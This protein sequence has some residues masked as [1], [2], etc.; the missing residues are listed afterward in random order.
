MHPK[1]Q[2]IQ[3]RRTIQAA[4]KN[5]IGPSG[6]LGII[7]RHLG[8]MIIDQDGGGLYDSRYI[9]THSIESAPNEDIPVAEDSG[10]EFKGSI[11]G[12]VFDGLSRGMHL[13]IKYL[14]E[15][16]ELSVYYKGYE[17]YREVAGDLFAYAPFPEWENL[18]EKL[19]SQAKLKQREYEDQMT[20]IQ[21]AEDQED[22]LSFL[23]HLRRRWGI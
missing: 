2:E 6:K 3:Q 10:R 14:K 22:R 15:S 4:S 9:E 23:D 12:V 8:H 7:A 11:K 21:K 18:I 19:Y 17:V 5:L 1:E 16:A 20:M 13:E